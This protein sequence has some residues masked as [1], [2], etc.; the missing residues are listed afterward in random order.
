M[1]R[2][3]L[4]PELDPSRAAD[5]AADPR[6]WRL[7]DAARDALA[8]V[9]DSRRD[10]RRFRPDPVDARCSS[11]SSRR[12]TPLR[13]SGCR[14]PGASS[15]SAPPR[16]ARACAR[17][18]SASARGRPPRFESARP[19]LPGPEGRR[20]A[21]GARRDVRVLRARRPRDRG[22]GPLDDPRDRRLLDRLR[23]PEPV[24]HRARRG[25]GRRVGQL[26]PP[27]RA[28][29]RARHP[30]RVEPLAW[31]CL[32]WPDERP[33][34]PAS[35]ARAGRP[36]SPGRVVFA[37]RW[38]GAATRGSA[39]TETATT[40]VPD[41]AARTAARDR[42][43]EL[44][45]PAGASGRSRTCRAL[46]GRDRRTAAGAL[47]RHASGLRRRPRAR[48]A[49][50][51]PVRAPSGPGRGRGRPRR[52]GDRRPRARA[53]R[54]P[55]RSP[56]SAWRPTPPRLRRPPVRAGTADFVAVPP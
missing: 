24:A 27:R 36:A 50:V 7:D 30:R 5:R 46:G 11:G 23:D 32:G 34:A 44:V 28:A 35:S 25:P 9:I 56:T 29:R 48:A 19:S 18:P 55:P 17:W 13:R 20:C 12:R 15:S 52:D 3:L 1:R 54:D 42:A 31:L 2:P 6:G 43:D 26:L 8:V 38:T 37:E 49:R 45:K 22:P 41:A 53:R 39:A 4:G 14:S 47:A 40:P 16:P 33:R 10:V 21:R 51:E